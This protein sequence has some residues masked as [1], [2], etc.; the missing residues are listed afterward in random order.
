MHRRN[1]VEQVIKNYKNHFI[2]ELST[3]DP[4]LPISEWDRLLYQCKITLN[5]L[6]NFRV[7]PALSAYAY[8]F[9]PYD[10]NK[11][12]MAPPGTRVIVHEK[13]GNRTSW[14]NHGTPGWY[15]SQSLDQIQVYAV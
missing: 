3:T 8:L 2:Y 10:F 4:D 6:R 9:G 14:G 7:N 11:S 12:P 1:V 15:I 5:I 13:H